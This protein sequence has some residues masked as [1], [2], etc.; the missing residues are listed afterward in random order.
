MYCISLWEINSNSNSIRTIDPI[1]SDFVNWGLWSQ[2][3]EEV[4]SASSGSGPE[5][6]SSDSLALHLVLRDYLILFS[7]KRE[8]RELFFV[9]RDS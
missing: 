2:L 6:G 8:L 4:E 9:I 7:V 3:T 5:R 1:L